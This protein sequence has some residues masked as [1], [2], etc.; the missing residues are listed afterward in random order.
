MH[1]Y[2]NILSVN[3]KL[4]NEVILFNFFFIKNIKGNYRYE[5]ISLGVNYL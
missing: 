5:L 2:V 3:E 1:R 4:N